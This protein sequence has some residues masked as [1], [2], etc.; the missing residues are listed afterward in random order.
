MLH[1]LHVE[2]SSVNEKTNKSAYLLGLNPRLQVLG[3]KSTQNKIN[4]PD[5]K[6]VSHLK[7]GIRAS[8]ISNP[9]NMRYF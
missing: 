7:D 4:S 5:N 9:S 1:S 2:T 6:E 8:V 3:M